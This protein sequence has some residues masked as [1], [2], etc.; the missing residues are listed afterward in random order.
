MPIS[1]FFYDDVSNHEPNTFRPKSLWTPPTNRDD[2]L[3]AFLNA[4]KHELLTSKPTRI[5]DNLPKPQR[6]A[7]RQLKQRHDIIIKSA[8]KGSAVVLMDRSRMPPTTEQS[9]LLRT[10]R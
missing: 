8:D 10:T 5:R 9:H 1:E 6:E 7:L 3:N 4:V 2:G